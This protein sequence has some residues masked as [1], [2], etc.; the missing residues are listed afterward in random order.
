MSPKVHLVLYPDGDGDFS[1]HVEL[2]LTINLP[3][4]YSAADV[5]RA[6]EER[7]REKYPLAQI[8]VSPPIDDGNPTWEIYRDGAPI[9]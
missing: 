9:A 4:S 3:D 2:N 5:V 8:I 7:L 6:I 1:S